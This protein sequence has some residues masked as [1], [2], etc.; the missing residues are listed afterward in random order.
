MDRI[1]DFRSIPFI[2][3]PAIALAAAGVPPVHPDF[4]SRLGQPCYV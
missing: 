1:P 3:L 2:H 4:E